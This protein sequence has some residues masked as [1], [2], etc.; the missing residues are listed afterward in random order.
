M[1]CAGSGPGQPYM[2]SVIANTRITSP[3]HFQDTRHIELDL[4]GSGISYEPGDLLNILPRQNPAAVLRFLRRT[5]LDAQSVVRVAATGHGPQI[6]DDEQSMEV[7]DVEMRP[8]G[9]NAEIV[10]T[11]QF[12]LA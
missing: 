10:C 3:A 6:C 7:S 9:C 12:C 4:A 8:C 5:G 11:S 1:T 2:A